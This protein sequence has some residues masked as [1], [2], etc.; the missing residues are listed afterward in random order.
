MLISI[1]RF[2]SRNFFNWIVPQY[3]DEA[4]DSLEEAVAFFYDNEYDSELRVRG[5]NTKKTLRHPRRYVQFQCARS[6]PANTTKRSATRTKQG[7]NSIGY[8]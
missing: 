4:F 5:T 7:R 6:V 8:R 3:I 2:S 1:L